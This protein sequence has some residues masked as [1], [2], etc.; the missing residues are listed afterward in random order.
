M[1]LISMSGLKSTSFL[2]GRIA[3]KMCYL[4]IFM[5]PIQKKNIFKPE[6]HNSIHTDKL[7]YVNMVHKL[8]CVSALKIVN[9]S[10]NAS[11]WNSQ[12]HSVN[13]SI[14][15]ISTEYF[16]KFQ[17]KVHCGNVVYLPYCITCVLC[18]I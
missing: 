17:R 13:G 7:N 4:Y 8:T 3:S 9:P 16:L 10:H 18:I 6:L 14:N 1:F 5:S 2:T 15:M 11:F 12:T